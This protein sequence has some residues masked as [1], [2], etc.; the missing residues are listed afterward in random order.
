MLI[1]VHRLTS[2]DGIG[3]YKGGRTSEHLRKDASE[4]CRSD[5]SCIEKIL[6]SYLHLVSQSRSKCISELFWSTEL[7]S[8]SDFLTALRVYDFRNFFPSSLEESGSVKFN[9]HR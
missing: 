8:F 1:D 6:E 9:F 4:R 7:I 3:V 2:F 5:N